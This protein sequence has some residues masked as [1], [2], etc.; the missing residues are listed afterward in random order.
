MIDILISILAVIGGLSIFLI[1]GTII[2][3]I[4]DSLTI[5]AD[6][7]EA[8]LLNIERTMTNILWKLN[9]KKGKRQ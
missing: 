1:V 5:K 7:K 3:G 2:T 4:W 6:K 9:E 8:R